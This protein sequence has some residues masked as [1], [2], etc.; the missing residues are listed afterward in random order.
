MK[1]WQYPVKPFLFPLKLCGII[2]PSGK[3][4]ILQK[5]LSTY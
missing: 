3:K 5:A 1:G 2:C 4:I